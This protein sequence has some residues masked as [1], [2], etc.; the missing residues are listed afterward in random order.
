M[1]EN[2]YRGKTVLVTGDTGFKGSWVSIWLLLMGARVVGY[3]LPPKTER[4]N[5]VACGLGSRL[6]H[7]DGDIRDYET[8]RGVYR[9]YNPDM[10]FHLAAQAIVSESYNDPVYTFQTNVMGTVNVLEAARHT[11]SV[12]AAVI[13][14]S[15]KCYENREWIYGYREVDPLGGRDPYSASKG[16]AEIVVSSYRESYFSSEGT[17][18]IASVRAGNVIGGGD[19]S[20]D[21]IV[22]DCMRA[23]TEGREIAVRNPDAVRPWQHVLEPLGGYL[24]LGTHLLAGERSYGTSWNFGP[25]AKNLITVRSLVEELI[26]VWGTGRYVVRSDSGKKAEANLLVLD[27]SKAINR[28][29]WMPVLDFRETVRYTAEDYRA[30]L[31]EPPGEKVFRQRVAHIEEYSAAAARQGRKSDALL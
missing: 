31:T 14:T 24:L 3:A 17:A 8:L 10:I 20:Q 15:D 28:L 23:L 25:L 9:R 5:Y 30:E 22:P 16:A 1:W 26:G 18:N 12:Q 6:A 13:V 19:W 11:P 4:D 29:K 2:S 7:I 21:R 27:I